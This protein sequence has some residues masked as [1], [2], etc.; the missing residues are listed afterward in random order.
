MNQIKKIELKNGKFFHC[1]ENELEAAKKIF[2]FKNPLVSYREVTGFLN[3][4]KVVT[5]L[6]YMEKDKIKSIRDIK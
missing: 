5:V 1:F 3:S 4:D 6:N 2:S